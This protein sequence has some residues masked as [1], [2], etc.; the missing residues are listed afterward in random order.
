M[1][2]FRHPLLSYLSFLS[3]PSLPIFPFLFPPSLTI[4]LSLV[5]RLLPPISSMQP[6][7]FAHTRLFHL[8]SSFLSSGLLPSVLYEATGTPLRSRPPTPS[9]RLNP[10]PW[11]ALTISVL[12]LRFSCIYASKLCFDHVFKTR[13][14]NIVRPETPLT[15]NL[16][17]DGSI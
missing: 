5:P 11:R 3:P 9:F 15:M 10:C 7:L 12:F 13:R 6:H 8:L 2:T 14:V 1:N 16:E 4:P 17:P